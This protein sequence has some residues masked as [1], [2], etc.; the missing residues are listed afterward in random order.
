DFAYRKSEGTFAIPPPFSHG[1]PRW[2]IQF[3]IDR[4]LHH[5]RFRPFPANLN[6]NR[7]LRLRKF[8]R[9][10]THPNPNPQ[11]RTLRPAHDFPDSH[12]A[13]PLTFTRISSNRADAL[14]LPFR[15]GEG[16]G[17]GSATRFTL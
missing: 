6:F 17:E 4:L 9:H 7:P 15:R 12:A 5:H 11:R 14:P 1:H 2:S 8:R 10:I 13:L 16:R 3:S